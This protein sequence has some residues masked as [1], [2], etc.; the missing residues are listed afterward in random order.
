[1]MVSITQSKFIIAASGLVLLLGGQAAR[2]RVV[3][4]RVD[5]RPMC[6]P[7]SVVSVG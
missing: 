5:C 3:L 2:A 1:M 4:R 6:Q 7:G